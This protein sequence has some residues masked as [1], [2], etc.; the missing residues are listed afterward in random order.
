V[1]RVRDVGNV[2]ILEGRTPGQSEW[3]TIVKLRPKDAK[4]LD[5]FD[6][7]GA[8]DK[9]GQIY[10]AVKPKDKSEG[11]TRRLR[12]YDLTTKKLSDPIWPELKYDLEDI[13]QN[14]ETGALQ[15]V[16]YT[17]DVYTCDFKD[18]TI[19]A[20]FK[21]ISKFFDNDRSISPISIT[22]DARWWL[23]SVSGPTICT[24]GRKRRS[25]FWPSS[26]RALPPTPWPRSCAGPMRR[27]TAPPCQPT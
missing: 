1:S 22:N 23:F 4:V 21:A 3:T 12:V 18:P 19:Q 9:P 13:V 25:T 2:V 26:T 20:N 6:I 10:V 7:L 8:A 17:A 5:D 11:E 24:T 14:E 16:C 27:A 15:G